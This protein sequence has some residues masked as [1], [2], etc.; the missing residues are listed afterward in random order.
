MFKRKMSS[1]GF[2]MIELLVVIAVIGILAVA[3]LAT[4]NP[5]EQIRKGRDTRTRS[6]MSQMLS[7]IERYN[8]S[9]GYMPWQVSESEN[10]VSGGPDV[11]WPTQLGGVG[12]PGSILGCT[13]TGAGSCTTL[14]AMTMLTNTAEVKSSFVDRALGETY[15]VAWIYYDDEPAGTSVTACFVPQSKTFSREAYDRCASGAW[16]TDFE[17]NVYNVAGS[18]CPDGADAD[19]YAGMTFGVSGWTYD[20]M[21]CLP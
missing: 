21:I 16:G 4:L 19:A 9:L 10:L 11:P 1:L 14:D 20:E 7:A 3:L 17:T 6:D 12:G 5:L 18:P 13:I 15:E 8:A 2:T